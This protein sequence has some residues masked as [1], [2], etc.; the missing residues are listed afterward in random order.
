M[1]I[2]HFTNT[3]CIPSDRELHF[4]MLPYK[5]KK[6][7]LHSECKSEHNLTGTLLKNEEKNKRNRKTKTKTQR[8]KNKK[9]SHIPFLPKRRIQQK[10]NTIHFSASMFYYEREEVHTPRCDKQERHPQAQGLKCLSC[11]MYKEE[12]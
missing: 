5:I 4:K 6:D 2:L 12:F 1:I 9:F 8:K 3:H 7:L 11:S 10:K